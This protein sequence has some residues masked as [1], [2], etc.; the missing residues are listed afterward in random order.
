M[1]KLIK[2]K[3]IKSVRIDRTISDMEVGGVYFDDVKKIKMGDESICYY[4]GLP[5]VLSY[6]H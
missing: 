4:S 5:S 6:A 3:K 2:G 1:K